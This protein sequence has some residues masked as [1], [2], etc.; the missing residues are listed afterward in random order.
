[1]LVW[2]LTATLPTG[3]KESSAEVH[4]DSDALFAKNC[5]AIV[6][7]HQRLVTDVLRDQQLL[8]KSAKMYR[9]VS[10][11]LCLI[12]RDVTESAKICI[13]RMQI[14]MQNP[15]DADADL[16]PHQNSLVP[17]IIATVIQRS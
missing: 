8:T 3:I 14:Y 1:M 13:N 15:S 6:H 11:T 12:N 5:C 4:L 16:S 17:A 2:I 10:D 7:C 9:S